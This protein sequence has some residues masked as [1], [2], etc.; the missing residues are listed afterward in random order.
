M[1]RN[2]IDSSS[3]LGAI[4]GYILQYQEYTLASLLFAMRV[5]LIELDETTAEFNVKHEIPVFYDW[6]FAVAEK[7]GKIFSKLELS[8]FYNYIGVYV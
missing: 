7:L 1:V 2:I 6:S 8:L 4:Q 5:G 3:E